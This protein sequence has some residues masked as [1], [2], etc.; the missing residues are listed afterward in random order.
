MDARALLDELERTFPGFADYCESM[1]NLFDN[2]TLGGVLAACSHFVREQ[3][4]PADSWPRL[5]TFVN[6]VAGGSDD[7]AAEAV[8]MLSREPCQCVPSA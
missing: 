5:A 1:D 4:V 2:R 7:A 3:P 8:H 6:Q